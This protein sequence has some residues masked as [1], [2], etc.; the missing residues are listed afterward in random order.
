MS[1]TNIVS[2]TTLNKI[3]HHAQQNLYVKKTKET[4]L[5]QTILT[6][7][8]V[9]PKLFYTKANLIANLADWQQPYVW[10]NFAKENQIH[11]K[12]TNCY[13]LLTNIIH[14]SQKTYASIFVIPY[15]KDFSLSQTNQILREFF[16]THAHKKVRNIL[17]ETYLDNDNKQLVLVIKKQNHPKESLI[18]ATSQIN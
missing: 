3:M 6:M 9:Q 12:Q 16:D 17:L 8:K 1:D 11:Y 15:E 4:K 2:Q 5:D 7:L 18:Y 14:K 13:H 10:E